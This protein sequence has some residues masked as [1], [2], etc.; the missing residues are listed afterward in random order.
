MT[1]F[2]QFPKIPYSTTGNGEFKITPDIL[3][4][5]G[6]RSQAMVNAFRMRKYMVRAGETPESV[7]YKFYGDPRLHWVILISNNITDRYHDWPLTEGQLIQF[8]NDKYSD[9]FGVHH[10]EINQTSG[11]TTLKIDVG[12]S[13]ADYPTATA[14]TN[15]EFEEKEQDKKRKI[16]LLDPGYVPQVVEEFQ[17][18][19]N[20]SD[21]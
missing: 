4:R 17:E 3:R 21:I 16:K 8:V 12:T 19:I 7:A 15:F 1:Y 2:S 11:D 14:V 10:Y 18:M 13:N 6:M 5:V 9:P 20:E